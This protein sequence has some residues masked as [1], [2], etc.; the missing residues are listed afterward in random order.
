MKVGL[1][2]NAILNS[3]FKKQRKQHK[4][5]YMFLAKWQ[6]I[7]VWWWNNVLENYFLTAF[8]HLIPL[9]AS[10][11]ITV[12][13]SIVANQVH[14]LVI[15]NFPDPNG[16]LQQHNTL[17]HHLRL[18]LGKFNMYESLN[19]WEGKPIE[20]LL[21]EVKIFFKI[22]EMDFKEYF[23]CIIYFYHLFFYIIG[24]TI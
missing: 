24:H 18:V 19:D 8:G 2:L 4:F 17:C 3:N 22:L 11:I 9:E 5:V 13:I 15:M 21:N 10:L 12:Y 1:F 23:Y 16:D 6:S 20:R 7:S 14:V